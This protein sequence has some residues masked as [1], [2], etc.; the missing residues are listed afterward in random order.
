MRLATRLSAAVAL[1]L[2]P[3]AV[4][5]AQTGGS[6]S[7]PVD[8]STPTR[9]YWGD[10]H[11]HTSLSS[12][13]ANLSGLNTDK[14]EL[15]YRFARGETVAARNGMPVRLR[16]PLDFLV[17]ADHAEG[18]GV[19]VSLQSADPALLETR[20]GRRL[21]EAFQKFSAKEPTYANRRAFSGESSAMWGEGGEPLDEGY[22]RTVWHRVVELADVY[23]D[24]GTFT[25]L[26]GYEWTSRGTP[27]QTFG[28]LH[29][30]V[31]FKDDASKTG[32][33]IPFS[34]YDSRNPE[35]LWRFLARYSEATGGEVLAIPHNANVSNGEM[36]ALGTFDGGP[37]SSAYAE[38]RGRWEPLY[39][40]TQIKGDSETHPVLSPT[41]EF[42]DFET[43]SSW[44][45]RLENPVEHS[46]CGN[47]N[48]AE[49]AEIKKA[50]YARAALKRGLRLQA[51]LG[52]NP[53]KFGMIGSTDAHTS[54]ATADNDNFWG[55]YSSTW[56]SATRMLE[57]M[58]G[59][60]ATPLNW[61][62]GAAGYAAVWAQ[63]NTRDSIFAAMK[64]KEVYASSGPRITVRFFGG[65]DYKKDEVHRP[66][67]ADIGYAKGVPM[68][69]DLSL[70]PAGGAPTFLI[71][72]LKDPDGANLDRAQVVKGWRDKAGELHEK[73]YDV[74][75]ADGRKVGAGGE[76]EPVGSTVD[77]AAA[78]YTNTIGDAELAVTWRDPDFDADELAF[79]YLRVLQI[80]TPRWIAFDAKFYGIENIPEEVRMVS[81]ERVYTS[82]IWYSPR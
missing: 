39:E 38:T 16:R 82:P 24:P 34:A 19:S 6:Y 62:T 58:V 25:A 36:F 9:V 10:T 1:L 51:E 48:A 49:Q 15:A 78:S 30:V 31:V 35:D 44:A 60:W 33:I 69:G 2:F 22:R 8:R 61:E 52:V 54:F 72:A 77:V 56:P 59:V 14:P 42:A 29:R 5:S 53:F 71:R 66:D 73:V 68:G 45:G 81:Q 17:I 80:P 20:M 65:W 76:V 46:C 3:P 41:D 57:P 11:V 47:W 40:V 13:D 21:N 43:W 28:N 27:A 70:G 37:L 50:E 55:K 74:A 26:A 4:V 79:Y 67:F 12:S 18:L 32:T 23:N 7:S 64:R 63:E 75:L